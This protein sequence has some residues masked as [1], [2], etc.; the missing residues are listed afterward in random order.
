MQDWHAIRQ[1]LVRDFSKS[2]LFAVLDAAQFE[3]FEL[4]TSATGVIARPLF[5][6]EIEIEALVT[7][8]H[9]VEILKLSEIDRVRS[10]VG[11]KPAAVWWRWPDSEDAPM[12]MY[13]HLRTLNMCALPKDRH[14]SKRLSKAKSEPVVFRH[15]DPN[16]I[17][18]ML[19]IFDATQVSRLFGEALAITVNAP[20]VCGIREFHRPADLPDPPRGF[21]TIRDLEQYE[22]ITKA[23]TD[24]LRNR[25]IRE[26]SPSIAGEAGAKSARIADAFDRAESYALGTQ[27]EIWEFIALDAEFG[28]R[29]EYAPANEATAAALRADN[30]NSYE[31]LSRVK[32]HLAPLKEV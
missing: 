29:F 6:D 11:D 13:R 4:E 10:L 9:L 30:L 5:L 18:M 19:P 16:V 3:N 20:D 25:A 14:D 26:L 2:R 27:S 8:P 31:K 12:D 15:A 22:Q 32:A 1:A 21:L 23:F 7:G 17:A 28:P 24:A